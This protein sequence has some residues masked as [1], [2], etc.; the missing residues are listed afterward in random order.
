MNKIR[1]NI[2]YS[3]WEGKISEDVTLSIRKF[4]Y[5]YVFAIYVFV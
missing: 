1:E 2:D 4:I 5:K 3:F